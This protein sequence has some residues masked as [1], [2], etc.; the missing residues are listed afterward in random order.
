LADYVDGFLESISRAFSDFASQQL[1]EG[2]FGNLTKAGGGGG[3]LGMLFGS[4]SAQG[5]VFGPQGL[6]PFGRGGV[7]PGPAVFPFA[8]G[9]GLMGERGPEAIMPLKRTPSG[10][11]GVQA[12]GGGVDVVINNYSGLPAT[13]RQININGRRTLMVDIGNDILS[14]GPTAQAIGSRFAWSP[15]GKLT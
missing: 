12:S 15:V 13:Q 9:I 1:I 14:G 6:K 11:L 4:T 7:V 2:L 8:G 10:D 5:N 3:W